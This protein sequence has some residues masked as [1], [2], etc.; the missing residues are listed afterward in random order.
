MSRGLGRLQGEI[1]AALHAHELLTEF[2]YQGHHFTPATAGLYDLREIAREVAQQLHR[3]DGDGA[4]S[5]AFSR[6][7]RGLVRRGFLRALHD[8]PIAPQEVFSW[9]GDRKDCVAGNDVEGYV[10]EMQ[11]FWGHPQIRFIQKGE[12]FKL[13]KR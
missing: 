4:F 13:D 1:L 5:A 8:I 9:K 6:A 12:A 3:Q 2:R 11:S 7:V 10:V